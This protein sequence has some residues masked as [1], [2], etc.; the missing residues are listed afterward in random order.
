LGIHEGENVLMNIDLQPKK[1]LSRKRQLMQNE[2][3]ITNVCRNNWNPFERVDPK[4]LEKVKRR[5]IKND[6]K[7]A[8]L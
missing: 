2:E 8:L 6:F 5:F 4:L 3:I 1:S 7:D